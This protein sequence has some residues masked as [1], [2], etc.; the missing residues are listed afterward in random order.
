MKAILVATVLVLSACTT[1]I[2]ERD[3]QL[4]ADVACRAIG[5]SL[6]ALAPHRQSLGEDV[7]AV[8]QRIRVESDPLCTG[9]NPPRTMEVANRLT[10]LAFD[11]MTV[12]KGVK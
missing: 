8:V 4:E 12:E 11:L 7:E 9:A 5:A 3:I 6:G 10:A 2:A 1:P